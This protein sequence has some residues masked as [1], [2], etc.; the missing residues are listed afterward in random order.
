M[1][2]ILKEL[3]NLECANYVKG[4]FTGIPYFSNRISHDLDSSIGTFMFK[5]TEQVKRLLL[6]A[7]WSPERLI[8]TDFYKQRL[9]EAGY[10]VFPAVDSFLSEF[11]DLSIRFTKKGTDIED[12]LNFEVPLAVSGISPL[13]IKDDYV[14]RVGKDLCIIGQAYSSHLTLMMDKEGKVYG[15]FD[16]SL[17]FVADSGKEAIETI[18]LDH[19]LKEIR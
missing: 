7:G 19:K 18:C 14:D 17:Y 12:F 8:N 15:A 1:K 5:F 13:W 16:D 9:M 6:N 4:K 3:D 11:G 10:E 2:M